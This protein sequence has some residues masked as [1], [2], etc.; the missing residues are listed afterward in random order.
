M[1]YLVL[2]AGLMGKEVVRDLLESPNVSKVVLADVDIKKAKAVTSSFSSLNCVATYVNANDE[3]ELVEL[4]KSFDV[5]INA[6]FYTFNVKVAKAAIKANVSLC[7]LGGHI[8]AATDQVLSYKEEAKNA[9]IT[10]IPDLGVAPGMINIL[11]GYGASQL[12]DVEGI[13]LRVGGIP[14]KPEPPLEYNQVFSM[15]GVFDHYTD[16]SLIIQD[17]HMK[18]VPSL[19]GIETLYFDRFGPLEA[20][21]TAGGTSTIS[22]SFSHVKHLDYK[23]IRYKGHAEKMKLL[24]DLNLTKD[25]YY[26]TLNDTK[27]KPRDVLL[28]TLE[29]IVKLGEKD[30]VVLLRVIVNGVKNSK[31]ISKVYEMVTYNNKERNITAMAKATAY[32]I[33]VV[34]QFIA[35]GDIVKTGAFPPEKIVPG[36]QYITEMAKRGVQITETTIDLNN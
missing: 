28:K 15:E 31:R 8:G 35:N 16:P 18:S 32:T 13:Q 12:D 4:L 9:G 6:L 5:V 10:I 26:V 2:G 25:D 27:I 19:S 23:T 22:E 24:V 17:G 36:A 34:A 14:V 29:P 20:F 7:D 21:H 30:D 33:S 3:D 11:T 1:N